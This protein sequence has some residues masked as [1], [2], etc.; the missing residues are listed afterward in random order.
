MCRCDGVSKY[1][2]KR[3]YGIICFDTLA[4]QCL[5][6]CKDVV[7][8]AIFQRPL[9][10]YVTLRYLNYTHMSL[11]IKSNQLPIGKVCCM[12]LPL[13]VIPDIHSSTKKVQCVCVCYMLENFIVL[14]TP[15]YT[16]VFLAVSQSNYAITKTTIL[17]DL[18][19]VVPPP[20]LIERMRCIFVM[21]GRTEMSQTPLKSQLRR[22][23]FA[24]CIKPRKLGEKGTTLT[25]G[26]LL[27]FLQVVYRCCHARFLLHIRRECPP[28]GEGNKKSK[29]RKLHISRLIFDLS[30]PYV[31]QTQHHG[32]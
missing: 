17:T 16:C 9:C 20:P 7:C 21:I 5:T 3:D 18:V 4:K 31:L 19:V 13:H 12:W 11:I 32:V 1:V 10:K 27:R 6:Y 22:L 15:P 23:F 14:S 28:L 29:S 24:H 26:I 25:T 2:S 30:S 8:N